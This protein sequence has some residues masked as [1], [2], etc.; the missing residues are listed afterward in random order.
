MNI[1]YN[2][3]DKIWLYLWDLRY[4]IYS[5]LIM[6]SI[7]ILC[8]IF[9][10]FFYLYKHVKKLFTKICTGTYYLTDKNRLTL[11][12]YGHGKI[13]RVYLLKHEVNIST[14]LFGHL[15]R[16]LDYNTMPEYPK[17]CSIM[18]EVE[19]PYKISKLL[20]IDKSPNIRIMDNFYISSNTEYMSLDVKSPITLNE[21]ILNTKK[22]MGKKSFYRWNIYSGN[23]QNFCSNI[24]K[25]LYLYSK[26]TSN[27][28]NQ[29]KFFSHIY[30]QR[31][32]YNIEL[33]ITNLSNLIP[34]LL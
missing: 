33:L 3:L 10:L 29:K 17:H 11:K 25:S 2:F 32:F 8:I 12:S 19:L 34:Q 5:I 28:L 31:N 13:K 20:L 22:I 24:L 23:C 7:M 4:F 30:K 26:N 6:F 15:I 16:K 27:F 9:V 21:M 18:L 14:V 1:L